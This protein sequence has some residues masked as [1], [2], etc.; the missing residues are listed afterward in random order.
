[1]EGL[2]RYIIPRLDLLKRL[3]K[4]CDHDLGIVDRLQRQLALQLRKP[5]VATNPQYKTLQSEPRQ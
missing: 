3:R 4:A 5:F 1:M 2:L